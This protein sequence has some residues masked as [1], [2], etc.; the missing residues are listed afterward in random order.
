[1]VIKQPHALVSS[2]A[3]T[4]VSSAVLCGHC[5]ASVAGCWAHAKL[6]GACNASPAGSAAPAQCRS[7]CGCINWRDRQIRSVLFDDAQ[8]VCRHLRKGAQCVPMWASACTCALDPYPTMTPKGVCRHQR[9]ARNAYDVAQRLHTFSIGI[10][11]SPDLAAARDVAA[12]LGTQHHEYTFTVDE[13]IDAVYD[14]IYHIESFEQAWRGGLLVLRTTGVL[15]E[16]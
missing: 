5:V 16:R 10:A 9:E 8:G 12:F 14:L 15:S 11:G 4:Y 2:K 6:K 7:A 1:M 13:G 3:T